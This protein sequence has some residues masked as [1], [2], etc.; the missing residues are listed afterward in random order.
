MD[1][2]KFQECPRLRSFLT[3]A[4][5]LGLA[6]WGRGRV[7]VC[8]CVTSRAWPSAAYDWLIV[9]RGAGARSSP[10][11]L[12]VF[13]KWTPVPSLRRCYETIIYT[14][15]PSSSSSSSMTRPIFNGRETLARPKISGVINCCSSVGVFGYLRIRLWRCSF[16]SDPASHSWT[17]EAKSENDLV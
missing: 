12:S 6:I 13:I 4:N 17:M 15:P 3:T 14:R 7:A 5:A 16:H 10:S 8:V 11:G 9:G 2:F 1:S